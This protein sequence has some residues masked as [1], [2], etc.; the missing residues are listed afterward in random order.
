MKKTSGDLEKLNSNAKKNQNPSLQAMGEFFENAS[1]IHGVSIDSKLLADPVAVSFEKSSNQKIQSVAVS[2]KTLGS[3]QL[4]F[5]NGR[6]DFKPA[7]LSISKL[8]V[9][10]DQIFS[11]PINPQN[12]ESEPFDFK[13]Y[14]MYGGIGLVFIGVLIGSIFVA[15][16]IVND[17]KRSNPNYYIHLFDA[18]SE[19]VLSKGM[20]NGKAHDFF[21]IHRA[22]HERVLRALKKS[23]MNG[24]NI[25]NYIWLD[26]KWVT[27][28]HMA[29]ENKEYKMAKLLI[30]N[31]ADRNLRNCSYKTPEECIDKT[32]HDMKKMFEELRRKT[33]RRRLPQQF[34]K[35]K[36]LIF[37]SFADRW[38]SQTVSAKEIATHMELCDGGKY[39]KGE[40]HIDINSLMIEE[41]SS[42][43]YFFRSIQKPSNRRNL[44]STEHRK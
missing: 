8:Q 42:L 10:F 25:N 16:W 14:G 2:L 44:Q 19:A 43:K 23:V 38:K 13:T 6:S 17:R 33:F 4:D 32:D 20:V 34:P 37:S 41:P 31:G 24:A 12:A 15:R 7:Q 3:L 11:I 29:V 26:D 9:F 28:L 40:E 36:W 30:M 1:T 5:S 39:A 27:P 22:I 35:S 21:P 18:G